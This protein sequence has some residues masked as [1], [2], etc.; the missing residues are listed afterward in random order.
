M[1]VFRAVFKGLL[2]NLVYLLVLM[3]EIL[4]RGMSSS[5][6]QDEV[7]NFIATEKL[8]ICAILETHLI[9]NMLDKAISITIDMMEFNDC[10]NQVEVEDLSSAGFHFT[11]TKNLHKVKLGDYTVKKLDRIMASEGVLGIVSHV[12]KEDLKSIQAAIDADPFDKCLRDK[13][14]A[15]LEKYVEAVKDEEK[16]LFQKC[17]IKWLSYGDKNNSFFH[18]MLKGRNQRNKFQVIHVAKGQSEAS[19][20]VKPV[21]DREIK[22]AMFNTNDNKAPGPNGSS[23]KFFKAAWHI[24]GP[25]VCTAVKEFFSSGKL[26]G[27]LNATIISLIPKINTPLLRI[28]TRRPNV[29][30]SLYN[31]NGILY[32]GD[33]EEYDLM[34][35]C[36]GDLC[37]VNVIKET[38][39]E[40][41]KCFGLLLNFNKS[42][43]FL[44]VLRRMSSKYFFQSSPLSKESFLLRPL[45]NGNS[46]R[47]FY[48][49]ILNKDSCVADMIDNEGWKNGSE[50]V[51]SLP[52]LSTI[53]VPVVKNGERDKII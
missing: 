47:S 9:S 15:I 17:K 29:P 18:K 14:S 8:H 7:I 50:W 27:E 24:V 37:S 2:R 51:D 53:V 26:L 1:Q 28:K 11:W 22:K 35:F 44:V 25:D 6:K 42:T 16:L 4:N 36:H 48:N 52:C 39:D 40:F 19:Q 38:I 10:I 32:P 49:A 20:M 46:H 45:I 33:G 3:D 30:L 43:V 21:T 5:T 13:G 41:G 31:G 34:V 12:L 23:T